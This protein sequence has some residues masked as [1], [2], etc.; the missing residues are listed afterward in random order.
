MRDGYRQLGFVPNV[1]IGHSVGGMMGMILAAEHPD[2]FRGLV[3]VDIAPFAPYKSP[4]R[5]PP[6]EFFHDEVEARN[7]IRERY[8]GFPPEAIENRMRHAFVVDER[9]RLWLKGPQEKPEAFENHVQAFSQN[10]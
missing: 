7:Y 5:P 8:P 6:P 3:L 1:L 9:G 2:E 4:K 10:L